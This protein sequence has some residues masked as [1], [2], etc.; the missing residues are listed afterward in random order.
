MVMP[1]FSN[2]KQKESILRH[3]A[4]NAFFYDSIEDAQK[5]EEINK[6]N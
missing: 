5:Q 4:K 6:N 1:P 2:I 3:A